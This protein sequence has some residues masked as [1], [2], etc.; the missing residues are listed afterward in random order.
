MTEFRRLAERIA[1]DIYGIWFCC[2]ELHKSEKDFFSR[3]FMPSI[4]ELITY[5]HSEK[6][7]MHEYG[8]S[9]SENNN[10][11]ILALLFAEQLWNDI[12][13]GER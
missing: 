12:K 13:E 9:L 2:N 11:R 8:K 1:E 10:I 7:W 5:G 3:W 4:D 6:S